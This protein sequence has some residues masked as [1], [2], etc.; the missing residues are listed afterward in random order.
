MRSLLLILT[1]V[2]S[3]Y[4]ILRS[5]FAT[6]EKLE[7]A[8]PAPTFASRIFTPIAAPSPKPVDAS[9]TMRFTVQRLC[10]EWIRRELGE[11]SITLSEPKQLFADLQRDLFGNGLHSDSALRQVIVQVLGDIGILPDERDYVASG[12][13]SMRE[14]RPSASASPSTNRVHQILPARAAVS[15]SGD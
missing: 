4:L 14:V 10:E 6:D 7:F 1:L 11:N 12:I 13:L 5:Y 8:S 2:I 3:G 9:F 15:G